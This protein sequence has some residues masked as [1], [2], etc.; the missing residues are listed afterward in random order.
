MSSLLATLRPSGDFGDQSDLTVLPLEDG[1]VTDLLLFGWSPLV[2]GA[3]SGT[4]ERVDLYARWSYYST[5]GDQPD[6]NTLRLR[7]REGSGG[8]IRLAGTW[9][10]DQ[11]GIIYNAGPY[12]PGLSQSGAAWDWAKALTLE[13]Q[14]ECQTSGSSTRFQSGAALYELW[15]E[16]WGTPS[17]TAIDIMAVAAVSGDDLGVPLLAGDLSLGVSCGDAVTASLSAGDVSVNLTSG[18]D[19]EV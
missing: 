19:L 7:F 18:S 2:G 12:S 9:A 3:G 16:V 13:L 5:S 15:V 4:V 6:T 8:S 11:S 17:A 1:G 10:E 14:M